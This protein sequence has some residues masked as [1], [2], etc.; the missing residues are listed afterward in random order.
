M[1]AVDEPRQTPV[2]MAMFSREA[3]ARAAQYQWDVWGVRAEPVCFRVVDAVAEA[4]DLHRQA[5]AGMA[6]GATPPAL[7]DGEG[8]TGEMAPAVYDGDQKG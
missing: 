2:Y 1:T 5:T 6:F 3:A 4:K 7:K 8:I